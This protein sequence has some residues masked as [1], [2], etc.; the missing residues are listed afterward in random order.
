LKTILRGG[1]EL[2][3]LRLS[4][5]GVVSLFLASASFLSAQKYDLVLK[6]GHVI[7]AKNNID[8]VMDVAIL[9]GKISKVAP[10]IAATDAVRVADV[11]GF[12]VTPGLIDVHAHVYAGTGEVNSYAGDNSVYPD[13]FTFRVG[14]TTIVDAGCS[15]WRNFPDFKSRVIDRSQTRILVM[16]NIVGAGMRGEQYEQNVKD[17]DGET[18]GKFALKY[19]GLV[20]GIKSA[21]FEGGE[22]TPYKEAVKAGT[23]ANIPVMIDYGANRPE[24]PLYDLLS[25]V[26]R[27]G[28]IYTH[29]YSGLRGEQ[30]PVTKKASAA[31]EIGRKRGIYFDLGHGGGS[32]NWQVAVPLVENGFKPDSIST[33]LHI[34]SMN[35]GMKDIL[36]VADKMLALG[37]S[38]PE[39]IKDM[40]E[41]PAREIKHEE[42][43]NLSVGAP[44]DV[45]V[46][47]L[48]QG[49][50]GFVD[51]NNTVYPGGQKLE[52]E[53]TLRDG[54]VVYD[55]NG[56][57]AD[58]WNHITTTASQAKR[59][60]TMHVPNK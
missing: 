51:M 57:T 8:G 24:R 60:T 44:A 22:W 59:F 36:N 14:V 5:L 25:N 1:A 28:D 10:S 16:L 13:G 21:H 58:P 49:K 43:G 30:D 29:M 52:C 27:P 54:K 20:V 55:L 7:D 35:A 19:P 53:L 56:L 23:I 38:L 15:G 32:F 41:T 6:N 45:A 40:T 42:L 18:T 9:D 4:L 39:V 12:Y 48:Q 37:I 17:M 26:L 2:S 50:F 47:R 11:R 3:S 46:L 34:G 31:M 33:D